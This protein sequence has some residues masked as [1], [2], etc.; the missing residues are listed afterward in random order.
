MSIESKCLTNGSLCFTLVTMSKAK[1]FTE[2]LTDLIMQQRRFHV[3]LEEMI[4]KQNKIIGDKIEEIT[5]SK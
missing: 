4:K 3:E 1:T 5:K 2:S